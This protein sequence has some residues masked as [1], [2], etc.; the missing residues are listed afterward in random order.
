MNLGTFVVLLI[1]VLIVGRLVYGIIR[2][3][4]NGVLACGGDCGSCGSACSTPKMAANSTS[5]K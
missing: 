3:K 1:L 4:R 2:D 5:R